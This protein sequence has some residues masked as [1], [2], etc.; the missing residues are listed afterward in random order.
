MV[1][2]RRDLLAAALLGTA[3]RPAPPLPSLGVRPGRSEAEKALLDSAALAGAV[4]RAG[5]R[6]VQDVV[7]ETPAPPERQPT[8]PAGAARLAELLL[9]QPPVPANQQIPLLTT[10]L[11]TCAG[12]G[13]R[14]PYR[15]LPAALAFAT[16]NSEL[17]DPLAAV[18][19]TR[20]DWLAARNPIWRWAVDATDDEQPWSHLP[21]N[22]RI[23]ILTRLRH[24]DPGAAREL[25]RST[26]TTDSAKDRRAHLAALRQG[27][28]TEDTELVE[29][30]ADDRA[31]SVREMANTL[32]DGLPDSSRAMRMAERL[33]PLVTIGPTIEVALPDDPDA[34]GVRDGLGPP[35]TRGVST[36]G[37]WLRRIV[38]GTP[39]SWWTDLTGATPR[40]VMARLADEDV[41]AGL[42][43]AVLARGDQEWA[44]AILTEHGSDR[45]LFLVLPDAD[46]E[47]QARALYDRAP[48]ADELLRLLNG[49]SHEWT[50]E[51]SRWALTRM[52]A[53]APLG[54]VLLWLTLQYALHPDT[55]PILEEWLAEPPDQQ[56]ATALRNILRYQSLHLSITE[57]FR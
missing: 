27:L 17:R 54:P 48:D 26:W 50:V 33:R 45:D 24:T 47:T 15:L 36:R 44:R 5:G 31:V 11:S 20:G 13:F 21:S 23:T 22:A 10:W 40:Q 42:R 57:A 9:T 12:A 18:L 34:S 19:G 6:A 1:D 52:R 49:C 55:M 30:C 56:L 4:S 14:L 8:A 39:L 38:A 35:P 46:R 3:R 32:L 25:I 37:W 16:K 29:S 2:W 7:P 43:D 41:L 51:F 28:S 53:E